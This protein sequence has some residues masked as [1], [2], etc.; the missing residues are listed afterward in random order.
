[1]RRLKYIWTVDSLIQSDRRSL[2]D[3][4][5]K[6]VAGSETMNSGGFRSAMVVAVVLTTF[7]ALSGSW[8]ADA[9]AITGFNSSVEDNVHIRNKSTDAKRQHYIRG[10]RKSAV[11]TERFPD[12]KVC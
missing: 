11:I 8:V 10:E 5:V 6:S 12:I 4:V 2:P 9:V 1:M 3:F 7:V